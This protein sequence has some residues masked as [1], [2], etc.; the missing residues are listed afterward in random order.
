MFCSTS[1]PFAQVLFC[2]CMRLRRIKKSPFAPL[3]FGKRSLDGVTPRCSQ[4]V[5][6]MWLNFFHGSVS[7]I[8]KQLCNFQGQK[9]IIY[10]VFAFCRHSEPP[11]CGLKVVQV[12]RQFEFPSKSCCCFDNATGVDRKSSWNSVA[13]WFHG[14]WH[15]SYLTLC[16][17]NRTVPH[18]L[19]LWELK[20][21]ARCDFL[22][23]TV[24]VI[25]E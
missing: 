25:H 1:L 13:A 22:I 5:L 18:L 16:F 8:L 6:N 7:V 24:P 21:G 20:L 15:S 3:Q 10:Q 17:Q 9:L 14:M 4:Q 11:K 12:F 23:V 19:A 2:G